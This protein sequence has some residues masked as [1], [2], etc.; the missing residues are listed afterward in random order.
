[1]PFLLVVGAAYAWKQQQQT[2]TAGA[3]AAPTTPKRR[4]IDPRI[5]LRGKRVVSLG[6]HP[7]NT[8]VSSSSHH[9][10]SSLEDELPIAT[11]TVYE[12][13]K[14][15]RD[16]AVAHLTRRVEEILQLNPWLGG[17][18]LP[19]PNGLNLVYDPTGRDRA[20]HP[21]TVYNAPQP[22]GDDA[23]APGSSSNGTTFNYNSTTPTATRSTPDGS[24]AG[25]GW[26]QNCSPEF[27]D[28][29][30]VAPN[31]ALIGRYNQSLWKVALL[32]D[33]TDS[34]KFALVVSLSH[35]VGD[36]CTYY[37]LFNMLNSS[38]S[39]VRALDPVRV[40]SFCKSV[41]GAFG[42]TAVDLPGTLA[43]VRDILAIHKP[44]DDKAPQSSS[45]LSAFNERMEAM[46]LE[47]E[48]PRPN[49]NP[50]KDVSEDSF[51]SMTAALNESRSPLLRSFIL[52]Q[53]E[54][55]AAKNVMKVFYVLEEWVLQQQQNEAEHVQR[56]NNNSVCE[57]SNLPEEIAPATN[58]ATSEPPQMVNASIGTVPS[59][60]SIISSWF[61]RLNQAS[62][63]I[64]MMNMRHRLLPDCIITDEHA[65]NY[66][67][68]VVLGSEK[69]MSTAVNVHRATQRQGQ[70]D[71][72]N[73][74]GNKNNQYRG[75]NPNIADNDSQN[76]IDDSASSSPPPF[77]TCHGN[78]SISVNW[79]NLYRD[80]L[81][82]GPNCRPTEHCPM[83]DTTT[84]QYLPDK[85]S[86]INL[87]TAR[88]AA[89][90]GQ[91]HRR[92]MGAF[93]VCQPSVWEKVM[94]SGIVAEMMPDI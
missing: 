62:T 60:N 9:N 86:A 70:L 78:T 22:G 8:T 81:F 59:T 72:C 90:D 23:K 32:P 28:A 80:E 54:T 87:F 58:A 11:C 21:L 82:L 20:P 27:R 74:T 7:I 91:G 44:N 24:F 39:A 26:F 2:A 53:N 89:E 16:A 73:D 67:H 37:Q 57:T 25:G 84:M 31:D 40:P 15:Y 4:P 83:Y 88:C 93:V 68:A 55:K 48:S 13:C 33:A 34:N 63:G 50:S 66:V 65:G 56:N 43:G 29:V 41:A 85:V 47:E 36:A 35:L 17:W 18:I 45:P 77:Q 30:L 76:K 10:N 61:F 46:A 64:V 5:Q 69:D 52:L 92:R 49:N 75:A 3:T 51:S 6:P 19:L 79:T 14:N 42:G 71:N 1:M 38:N 94:Q 12:G